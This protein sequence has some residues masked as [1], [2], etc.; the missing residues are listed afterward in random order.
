MCGHED[1]FD[2]VLS[3]SAVGNIRGSEA[4]IKDPIIPEDFRH[5]LMNFDQGFPVY[6]KICFD[7]DKTD[8]SATPDEAGSI[9]SG[10]FRQGSADNAMNCLRVKY[11]L[12]T[13]QRSSCVVE[14]FEKLALARK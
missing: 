2:G 10:I 7:G 6:I 1:G 13:N 4:G 14:D 8:G 3:R 11:S 12:G 5:V 9:I